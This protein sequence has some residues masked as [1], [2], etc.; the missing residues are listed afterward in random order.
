MNAQLITNIIKGYEN[1]LLNAEINNDTAKVAWL[2]KQIS[3]AHHLL[4]QAGIYIN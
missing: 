1:Q 4:A 3:E 2:K